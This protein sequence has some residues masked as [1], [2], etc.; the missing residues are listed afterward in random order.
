MK[1]IRFNTSFNIKGY[2][3]LLMFSTN[4][5][6]VTSDE[7]RYDLF[8]LSFSPKNKVKFRLIFL[9]FAFSIAKK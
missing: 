4:F 2:L 5:W 6:S 8:L 1:H 7:N 3:F 9:M